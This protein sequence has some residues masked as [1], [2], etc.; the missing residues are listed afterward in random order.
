MKNINKA[1]ILGHLGA[2]PVIR[3]VGNGWKNKQT[4]EREERTE[5]HTIELWIPS[6][7]DLVDRYLGKGSRIYVEGQIQTRKWTDKQ[8]QD[9]YTTSIAVR[10]FNGCLIML[11]GRKAEAGYGTD[12]PPA[13]KPSRS[14]DISDDDIPF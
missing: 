5:W 11:D 13:P 12:A 3:D 9:R 7:V 4:G 10:P 1:Q 8:G 2:D 14:R 6:L